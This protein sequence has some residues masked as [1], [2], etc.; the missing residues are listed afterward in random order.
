MAARE[1]EIEFATRQA[2]ERKLVEEV[3]HKS[4]CLKS[5]PIF[6]TKENIQCKIRNFIGSVGTID[7]SGC[8]FKQARQIEVSSTLD[9]FLAAEG[10]LMWCN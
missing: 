4:A 10:I 1:H 9:K 2:K 8:L 7:T 3:R 6:P 5:S